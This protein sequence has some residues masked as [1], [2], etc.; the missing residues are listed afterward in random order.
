MVVA[1]QTAFARLAMA[2]ERTPGN[3]PVTAGPIIAGMIA[4][5]DGL[6]FRHWQ[7]EARADGVVVVTI[8]REGQAVNALSQAMLV[9]L[10][11]LLERLAIDPPRE[12][13]RAHV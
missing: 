13:G 11:E 3:I 7:V 10:G 4:G 1:S 5:F 9:E 2:A 8:D 12:I 6:R